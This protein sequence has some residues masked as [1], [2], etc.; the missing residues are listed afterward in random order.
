M[1]SKWFCMF[2]LGIKSRLHSYWANTLLLRLTAVPLFSTSHCCHWEIIP[3]LFLNFCMWQLLPLWKLK[4][5]LYFLFWIFTLKIFYLMMKNISLPL[6][7]NS[8]CS[9]LGSFDNFMLTIWLI[10]K[11]NLFLSIV[12]DRSCNFFLCCVFFPCCPS[13]G[14]FVVSWKT[15]SPLPSIFSVFFFLISLLIP[16]SCY[17]LYF[18]I[19]SFVKFSCSFSWM[20]LLFLLRTLHQ[21]LAGIMLIILFVWFQF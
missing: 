12:H 1:G 3:F 8:C 9:H 4:I 14:I 20:Y 15:S 5:P 10:Y 17:S 11:R 2:I 7:W 18:F 19:I 21:F 6:C 16:K 13:L